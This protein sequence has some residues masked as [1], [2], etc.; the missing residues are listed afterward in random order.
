MLRQ[1]SGQNGLL[2]VFDNE[3]IRFRFKLGEYVVTG[4]VQYH[5]AM[6]KMMLLQS[7]RNAV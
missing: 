3:C 5:D 4:R 6:I 2:N 1:V 7:A